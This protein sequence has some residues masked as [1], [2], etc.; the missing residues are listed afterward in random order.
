MNKRIGLEALDLLV[1]QAG[2]AHRSTVSRGGTGRSALVV[3]VI[4][5]AYWRR[6]W[7]RINLMTRPDPPADFMDGPRRAAYIDFH[8]GYTP[9][10]ST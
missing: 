2:R 1:A 6:S 5:A 10:L 4:A 3:G 8:T 7:L 9:G